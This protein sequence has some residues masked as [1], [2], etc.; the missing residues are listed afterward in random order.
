MVV[1]AAA[2]L[3]VHLADGRTGILVYWPATASPERRRRSC[4]ARAKVMLRPG[5]YISVNTEQVGL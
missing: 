3:P 2:R 5:V 4:G 1:A